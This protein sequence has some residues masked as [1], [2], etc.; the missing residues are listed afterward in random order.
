MTKTLI[1]HF[2]FL[3]TS[4]S[5]TTAKLSVVNICT[6]TLNVPEK[7]PSTT[8]TP[9]SYPSFSNLSRDL[10]LWRAGEIRG[11]TWLGTNWAF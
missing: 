9:L 1:I 3:L 2:P 10:T 7:Y 4:I 8:Y 5:G 6:A 11:A